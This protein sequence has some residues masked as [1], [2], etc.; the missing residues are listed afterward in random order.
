MEAQGDAAGALAAKAGADEVAA[1]DESQ[2]PCSSDLCRRGCRTAR[3]RARRGE[4]AAAQA[5]EEAA[6]RRRRSWPRQAGELEISLMRA[7]GNAAG[8]VAAERAL[9]LAATDESPRP[10]GAGLCRPGR[11]RRPEGAGR[12]PRRRGGRG[13]A[14]ELADKRLDLEIRLLRATGNEI[15]AVAMERSASSTQLDPNRCAACWSRSMRPRI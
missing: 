14:Q 8:A 1:T 15:G 6:A 12:R 2:A 3:R 9:Q 5:A 10:A 4:A 7:L 11:R 13:A